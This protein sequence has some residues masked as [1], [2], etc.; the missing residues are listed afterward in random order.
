[1][2]AIFKAVLALSLFLA[3]WLCIYGYQA[4]QLIK[5]STLWSAVVSLSFAAI[6]VY[7]AFVDIK[8]Q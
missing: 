8:R 4:Q 1:M 3:S 7:F 6:F 5:I 2:N